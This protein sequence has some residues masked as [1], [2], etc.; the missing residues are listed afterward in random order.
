MHE[1][2][3]I[4]V[5]FHLMDLL[6]LYPYAVGRALETSMQ[7]PFKQS[8]K[9]RIKAYKKAIKFLKIACKGYLEEKGFEPK[10]EWHVKAYCEMCIDEY[11]HC[12]EEF[13]TMCE[14][15]SSGKVTVKGMQDLIYRFETEI[16]DLSKKLEN[17]ANE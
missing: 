16:S 7:A 15:N 13:K 9:K 12:S 10:V 8:V 4:A 11:I 6:I 17:E 14:H 1:E 2:L 5:R 3:N